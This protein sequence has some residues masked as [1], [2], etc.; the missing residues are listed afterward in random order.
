MSSDMINDVEKLWIKTSTSLGFQ[1]GIQ[2]TRRRIKSSKDVG[3]LVLNPIK[4]IRS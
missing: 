4:L 2:S 3:E 1:L